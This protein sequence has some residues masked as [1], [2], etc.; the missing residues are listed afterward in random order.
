MNKLKVAFFIDIAFL[1]TGFFFLSFGV[2]KSLR[3][4]TISCLFLASTFSTI[5]SAIYLFIAT[6][7]N[8]KKE[9]KKSEEETINALSEKLALSSNEYVKELLIKYFE[10]KNE[11]IIKQN[12][13]IILDSKKAVV[14]FDF[15]PEGAPISSLINAYKT[16]DNKIVFIANKY[17]SE[18]IKLFNDKSDKIK[19]YTLND[20]YLSL[21]SANLLPV[22]EPPK[23]ARLNLKVLFSLKREKAKRFLYLGIIMILLSGFTYFSKFYIIFGSVLL[24]TAL[25]LRFFAKPSEPSSVGIEI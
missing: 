8:L 16:A 19:L 22:Y 6:R 7:S 25:S 5:I 23:K 2:L 13:D 21:K 10:F 1:F 9:I 24:I 11:K 17:T 12:Q 18:T 15:N 14:K 3:L 20:L 4:S